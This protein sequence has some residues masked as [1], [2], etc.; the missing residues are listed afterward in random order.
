[1]TDLNDLKLTAEAEV[2]GGEG[3]IEASEFIRPLEEGTYTF[4]QGPVSKDEGYT[5]TGK[6]ALAVKFDYHTVEGGEKDGAKITLDRVNAAT[7]DRGGVR[8]CSL[9]DH[10][11]AVGDK[12][13][14]NLAD[15]NAVAQAIEAREG[16]RFKGIVRWEWYCP[17]C[18]KTAA[19]GGKKA[20][21]M[22]N[23]AAMHTLKC[24]SCDRELGAQARIDR[25]LPMAAAVSA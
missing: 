8:A 18:E 9:I 7:F 2:V 11:R 3:Y 17:D 23:G 21:L 20:G 16:T 13:A 6:G 1:M 12:G 10:L 4:I 15:A 24:P 22:P 5:A 19:K 14:Y 25:R